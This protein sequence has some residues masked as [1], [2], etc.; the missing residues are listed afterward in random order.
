VQLES[1]SWTCS[2]VSGRCGSLAGRGA[3]DQLIDVRKGGSVVFTLVGAVGAAAPAALANSATVSPPAGTVDPKPANNR[4]RITVRRGIV[5]T[6]LRVSITP[7]VATLTSGVP[8]PETIVTTNVG[9]ATAIGVRTCLSLPPGLTVSKATGGSLLRGRYC[10]RTKTLVRGAHVTFRFQVR[11]DARL[12]GR[13]HLV[14][15]AEASNAPAVTDTS[16]VIVLAAVK[17]H[18]GG[19]TG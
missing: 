8:I 9:K 12:V 19:Y 7:P 10:W 6:R 3:I 1:F 4:D 2:A 17:K 14:A 13:T 5:P 16:R 11:G 18:E 15:A